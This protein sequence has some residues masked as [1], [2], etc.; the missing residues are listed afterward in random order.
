MKM[1]YFFVDWLETQDCGLLAGIPNPDAA[2]PARGNQLWWP[3]AYVETSDSIDG[4]DDLGM[5]LHTVFDMLLLQVHYIHI[6][7]EISVAEFLLETLT[8]SE[9]TTFYTLCLIYLTY[10]F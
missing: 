6:P 8:Y 1:L 7:S 2:V 4:V 3:M 5:A 10:Q 9:R